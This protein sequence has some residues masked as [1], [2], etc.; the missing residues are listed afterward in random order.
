MKKSHSYNKDLNPTPESFAALRGR[1]R[2][3]AGLEKR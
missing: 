1:F 3:G 2:G